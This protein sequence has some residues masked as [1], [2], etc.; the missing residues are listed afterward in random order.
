[1]QEV[2]QGDTKRDGGSHY[3]TLC[4]KVSKASLPILFSSSRE[5]QMFHGQIS[6]RPLKVIKKF[7]ENS[8]PCRVLP[9]SF[10]HT[11]L[12]PYTDFALLWVSLV[13]DMLQVRFH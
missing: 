1:M 12:C 5:E 13:S 10:P 7:K 3:G 11:G 2:A 8:R 6:H 9:L 4:S